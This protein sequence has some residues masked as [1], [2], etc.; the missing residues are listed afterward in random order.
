LRVA[1]AGGTG[2]I[3]TKLRAALEE[4]GDEVIVLTRGRTKLPGYLHWDA[5]RGIA[6]LRRLEGIDAFVNL[7]GEPLA[8]RPWTSPR[9]K[10]LISSRIQA[11]E[12]LLEAL[13]KLEQ[14]PPVVLGVSSLGFFGDRGNEWV[15]DDER[16]GDRFLAKLASGWEAA[17]LSASARFPCR[18]GVVRLSIVLGSD[19]GVFPPL[20]KAFRF[21]FGGWLGNGRQYVPWTSM[22]DTVRI[23]LHLLDHDGCEGVFNGSVPDPGTHR[24]WTEALARV[25]G[26]PGR[27]QAPAWALRGALGDL[28]EELLLASCR[29]RPRRLLGAGFEFA[30]PRI[31]ELMLRLT[32]EHDAQSR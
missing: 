25:L 3:G 10:V 28:A 9:R 27:A 2:W 13:T 11:T 12:I 14:P 22:R 32:S 20:L 30:D 5:S 21:G 16:P 15:E 23:L 24:D 31:E 1:I 7:A 29:A 17:H 8:T 26:K 19:G 4:R 6:R 18:V